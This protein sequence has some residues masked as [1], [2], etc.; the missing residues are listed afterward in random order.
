[1]SNLGIEGHTKSWEAH[2]RDQQ[3]GGNETPDHR[4]SQTLRKEGNARI[5][6]L[7]AMR[8]GLAKIIENVRNSR[9]FE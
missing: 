3:F 1:M 2:Q 6:M 4:K 8:Q 5:N 7:S 9:H